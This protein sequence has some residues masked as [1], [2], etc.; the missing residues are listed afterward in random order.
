MAGNGLLT[1]TAQ[2]V[3]ICRAGV[4]CNTADAVLILAPCSKVYLWLHYLDMGG[5][6]YIA[7]RLLGLIVGCAIAYGVGLLADLAIA[8]FKWPVFLAL[9]GWWS[10]ALVRV[11]IQELKHGQTILKLPTRYFPTKFDSF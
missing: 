11:M 2:A 5:G 1:A 9:A 7:A 6:Y 10:Y 4:S 3:G 8:G